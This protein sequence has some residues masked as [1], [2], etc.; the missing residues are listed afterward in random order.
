MTTASS[1]SHTYFPVECVPLKDNVIEVYKKTE[2]SRVDVAKKTSCKK[3]GKK[4]KQMSWTAVNP[5]TLTTD[6]VMHTV[7]HG[8]YT[9]LGYLRIVEDKGGIQLCK[10]TTTKITKWMNCR[11]THCVFVKCGMCAPEKF[12]CSRECNKTYKKSRV[13]RRKTSKQE[14]KKQEPERQFWSDP[15]ELR[16]G[17]WND[18]LFYSHI[19]NLVTVNS[20]DYSVIEDITEIV[21]NME[22]AEEQMVRD[23]IGM[24]RNMIKLIDDDI[25]SDTEAF[26]LALRRMQEK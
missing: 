3:F 16:L 23:G 26:I 7:P 19:P 13:K 14:S 24:R 20:V 22:E 25:D 9:F 17:V 15:H 1:F 18:D 2:A 21:R 5:S 6:R 11:N 10:C 12:V 8:V 4:T